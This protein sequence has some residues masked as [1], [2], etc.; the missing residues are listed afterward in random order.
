MTRETIAIHLELEFD[1][2]S[3]TGRA[4]DGTVE[5]R[6]S[7][8]LGLLAA[9]DALVQRGAGRTIAG[10]SGDAS[11]PTRPQRKDSR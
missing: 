3:L 2:D 1:G 6:F 10:T 9:I 7:G 8:W 5:K 4:A 11:E